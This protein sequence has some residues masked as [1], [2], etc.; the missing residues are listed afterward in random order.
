MPSGSSTA[1]VDGQALK[2]RLSPEVQLPA[3]G[4]E[5]WLQVLG[6]HTCFYKNEEI[7]Q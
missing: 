7:V 5:V 2:A 1:S 3:E 6:E 4:E